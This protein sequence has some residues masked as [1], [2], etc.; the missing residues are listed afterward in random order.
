VL[1]TLTLLDPDENEIKVKE[2]WATKYEDVGKISES[3]F[4]IPTDAVPGAWKI[5]ASSGSNFDFAEFDVVP[6]AEVEGITI[7]IE[8]IDTIPTIGKIVNIRVLGVEQSVQLDIKSSTGDIIG[9]HIH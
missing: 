6:D 2:T 4:R 8:G 9:E 7:I 5:K 3:G 1:V